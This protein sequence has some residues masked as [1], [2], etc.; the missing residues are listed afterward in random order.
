MAAMNENQLVCGFSKIERN[1]FHG[2]LWVFEQEFR[3]AT[4]QSM[5]NTTWQQ[6]VLKIPP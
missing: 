3:L 2:A 6:A 1:R 5:K 4:L